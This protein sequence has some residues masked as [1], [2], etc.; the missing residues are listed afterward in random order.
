MTAP[1]SESADPHRHDG[2]PFAIA[3]AIN[4][5]D[6][7]ERLRRAETDGEE[8]RHLAAERL[9]RCYR[10][11]SEHPPMSPTTFHRRLRSDLSHY[12]IL[13]AAKDLIPSPQELK[14]LF[15]Q[16]D[17]EGH[18][19]SALSAIADHL[20]C[21]DP[22]GP[23]LT[24]EQ[25][26]AAEV[27]LT[28]SQRKNRHAEEYIRLGMSIFEFMDLF[29]TALLTE[30]FIAAHRWPDGKPRCPECGSSRTSLFQYAT[31][32]ENPD[33]A[34]LRASQRGPITGWDCQECDAGFT[35]TT[36]TIFAHP[37]LP[38]ADWLYF[39]YELLGDRNGTYEFDL[40]HTAGRFH[41]LV[42]TQEEAETMRDKIRSVLPFA[43]PHTRQSVS[44]LDAMKMLA[45]A[46]AVAH[47]ATPS[48]ASPERP[49]PG[50]PEPSSSAKCAPS[51]RAE[52][53]N[54]VESHRRL[55]SKQGALTPPN[56]VQGE[57]ESAQEKQ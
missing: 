41:A 37:N 55:K 40:P 52:T 42:V 44:C 54:R 50:R 32:D 22:P 31:P 20:T 1:H 48:P 18:A 27:G 14:L 2:N 15:E 34:V 16:L 8:H 35:A 6:S 25:I 24:K 12:P 26:K 23:P 3:H 51:T 29:G 57:T 39:A 4:S 45:G 46:K 38:P 21:F 36:G 28:E 49:P 7:L 5:M 17:A 56:N 13:L 9:Y 19:K 33:P 11:L 10:Q 47:N 30:L 43:K 53:R